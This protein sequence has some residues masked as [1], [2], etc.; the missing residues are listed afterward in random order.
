MVVGEGGR[1]LLGDLV[2]SVLPQRHSYRTIFNLSCRCRRL[3]GG[4]AGLAWF[5]QIN[6]DEKFWQIDFHF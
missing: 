1:I 6:E 5:G 3:A 4:L 2:T